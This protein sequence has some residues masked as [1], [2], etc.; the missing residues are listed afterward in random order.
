MWVW[1]WV[2]AGI[3]EG[4]KGV[5]VCAV[6]RNLSRVELSFDLLGGE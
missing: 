2:Y 1:V 6:T 4:G 5:G 3:V